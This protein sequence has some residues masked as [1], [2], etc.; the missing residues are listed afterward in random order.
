MKRL[1]VFVV[2]GLALLGG[3]GLFADEAVLIDFSKLSADVALGTGSTTPTENTATL[4]DYSFVTGASFTDEEKA[5]MKMSLALDNWNVVLASSSRS[6]GNTSVTMAKQATTS[7]NAKQFNGQDMAN[8]MV[9]GVRVHFPTGPYNSWAMVQ[10]PFDIPVY[11]DKDSLQGAKMVVA[12]ADKGVGA[13]FDGYGVLKNVGVLKSVSVT[14]YGANFSNGLGLVVTDQDGAEQTLFM[15]YLE[16]DGWRTLT[17]Q[18][19]NYVTDV[20]DRELKKVSLY[21]KG[22]PFVKLVGI[23]IY[24]NADQEGGDFVTY[25]KD[26]KVTYDKA[27]LDIQRDI[28]DEA[29]WGIL[30][31]RNEARR[32]AELKNLGAI[33]VLRFLEKQKMDKTPPQE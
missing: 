32:M 24:R 3:T 10:P 17:W 33:Q 29:V 18:N 5:A 4:V 19:P 21:P 27:L 6:V 25:F 2:V 22:M 15:D 12:D 31:Q 23:V 9:L 11:A 1:C 20:R 28:N 26:I 14:A 7:R 13:K 16:F 8:K 30:Q